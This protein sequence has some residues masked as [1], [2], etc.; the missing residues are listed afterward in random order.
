[1][2][3]L[4]STDGTCKWTIA[5]ANKGGPLASILN[6]HPTGELA[7]RPGSCRII[8]GRSTST[9]GME[10]RDACV[11]VDVWVARGRRTDGGTRG[12]ATAEGC[13]APVLRGVMPEGVWR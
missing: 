9:C 4:V 5:S 8:A 3:N 2:R 7:A 1:M 11:V 12:A 10:A 13:D 6:L